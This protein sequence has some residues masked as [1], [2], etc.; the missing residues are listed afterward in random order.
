MEKKKEG[1]WDGDLEEESEGRRVRGG[2]LGKEGI[3]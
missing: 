1:K 2:D 3:W